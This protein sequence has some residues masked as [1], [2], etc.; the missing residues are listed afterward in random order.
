[1]LFNVAW[2]E[3]QFGGRVILVT[4]SPLAFVASLKA[5]DWTF[6]FCNFT[7]QPA[8]MSGPLAP[9]R[10]AIEAAAVRPPDLIEQG[11]LLWKVLDGEIQ[12]LARANP[13]RILCVHETLCQDPEK[14]YRQLFHSLGLTWSRHVESFLHRREPAAFGPSSP[15]ARVDKDFEHRWV[16]RLSDEERA[17]IH[18]LTDG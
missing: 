4:R 18:T 17:R 14:N 3:Q 8:L 2:F 5:R 10:E 9:H 15:Q 16:R 13:Q 12:A 11:C 1:M 6:D 7:R